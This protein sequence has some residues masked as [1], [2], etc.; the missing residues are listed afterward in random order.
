MWHYPS[1]IAGW[2]V[3]VALLL[4][5]LC[6][7]RGVL[8]S[9]NPIEQPWLDDEVAEIMY[10]YLMATDEDAR[11]EALEALKQLYQT[12]TT[13]MDCRGCHTF[14]EQQLAAQP[15]LPRRKHTNIAEQGHRN[16][17]DCHDM[18]D[19]TEIYGHN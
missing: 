5:L 19:L 13:Q 2:W 18:A 10:Q 11:V 7:G 16:C 9:Q 15:K 17:L 6:G 14:D 1:R 8:A 12:R 3:R 4:L